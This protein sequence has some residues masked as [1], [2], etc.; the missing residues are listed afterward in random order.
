VINNPTN[1][2]YLFIVDSADAVNLKDDIDKPIGDVK[3]AGGPLLT[4]R[5]LQ[6][7]ALAMAKYGHMCLYL[8]QV[9][10]EIKIDPYAKT[11][12][13]QVGG[14]GGSGVQHFSNEVLEY[15]EWY[16]G[17][18]ILE[19]P[20]ERVDRIKNRPVGHNVRI[21]LKKSDKENRYLTIEIPIK[22]GQAGGRSIWREREI[23]DQLL[24]WG[25][26]TK[27][28]SWLTFTDVLVKELADQ[29]FK[30]VPEKVQGMNQ[31]YAYL[32]GNQLVTS[33]LFTRF[34]NMISGGAPKS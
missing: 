27:G 23:A 10:S 4:K 14:S 2:R 8:G 16:E 1:T 11:T 3:V 21:K 7:F 29:G 5:F 18:L 33:Y 12:P 22:H 19:K 15:Q 31:L 25:L 26:V 20:D 28:G 32:E 17:D 9:T 30:D 34:K 24:A 13:R 6:K